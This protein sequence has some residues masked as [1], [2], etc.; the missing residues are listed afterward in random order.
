MAPY[1][2]TFGL[3]LESKQFFFRNRDPF[4]LEHKELLDL[5]GK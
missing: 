3:F 4:F 1:Y 5:F 2:K